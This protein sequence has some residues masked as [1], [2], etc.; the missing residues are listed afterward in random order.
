MRSKF[1]IYWFDDNLD[2]FNAEELKFKSIINELKGHWFF[3][4]IKFFVD[5]TPWTTH[6][7]LLNINHNIEQDFELEVVSGY[8]IDN[9]RGIDFN[10]PDLVVVDYNL[11]EEWKWDLIV[12]HIRDNNY[13]TDVL[14]YSSEL[15]IPG[16][17]PD[18]LRWEDPKEH[19]L[20][21][22]VSRDAVYCSARDKV[23]E[24]TW[25]VLDTLIKKVQ[26]L[27]NL[28]WLVMAETSEID[29]WNRKILSKICTHSSSTISIV[30]PSATR[31][32]TIISIGT[33]R[34]LITT[35]SCTNYLD[36]ISDSD[37][38]SASRLYIAVYNF[39]NNLTLNSTWIRIPDISDYKDKTKRDILAHQPE[40]HTS[41][42]ICMKIRDTSTWSIVEFREQELKDIRTYIRE[43]KK[44]L[45]DLYNA[46]P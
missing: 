28:R 31:N 13:Y 45:V 23:F 2:F 44:L 26:W 10:N 39:C 3:P 25:R 43:H 37:N 6:T 16:T 15:P 4:V 20:R 7:F 5:Q 40:E 27:N 42:R 32:T 36:I 17:I 46:L 30:P 11:S 9:I 33:Y 22:K 19:N 35:S 21:I 8:A 38:T 14:F 12:Q 34:L 24:K 29:E 1:I 18:S 41:T